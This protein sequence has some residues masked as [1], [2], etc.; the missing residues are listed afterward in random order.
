M[1]L[2]KFNK[3]KF[4]KLKHSKYG[5][6]AVWL[7]V[8]IPIVLSGVKLALDI[9]TKHSVD[10]N[11]STGKYYKRCATEAALAVAKNWNP[12]LTL[13]Q[14]KD[15]LLKIAD[16][17]YNAN[18]C[19]NDSAIGSAIPGLT[20]KKNYTVTKPKS[21]FA[22][23]I[24]LPGSVLSVN[25]TIPYSDAKKYTNRLFAYKRD[26]IGSTWNPYFV[27]WRMIDR[28]TS[29]A[30][31]V[32]AFDE[33]DEAEVANANFVLKHH[34]IYTTPCPYSTAHIC[35]VHTGSYPNV[36]Y[37]NNTYFA[38][39]CG[40]H[41]YFYFTAPSSTNSTTFSYS[42]NGLF[43]GPMGTSSSATSTYQKRETISNDPV[44]ISVVSDKIKVQTDTDTAY[45]VP[46]VC[47]VD[48]VLT[49]P[50]NAAASN[51]NNRDY[52]SDT[53][54][55]PS[56]FTNSSASLPT[57][58]TQ[59][60]VY[61]I[62]QALKN[63]VKENFYHTRGVNVGLIPYSA[64]VSLSPDKAGY[65][66]VVPQFDN[67]NFR[68]TPLSYEIMRGCFLYGTLG[69]NDAPL[70]NSYKWNTE[71]TGCPIMCRKGT[72]T[73]QST[74]AGNYLWQGDV[75]SNVNP[76]TNSNTLFLKMN[77]NP[78]YMG[79][80][81]LLSL[82]CEKT[83]PTYLP[84]P[85]Y[86]IEPTAD[87]VKIYE[88]CNAL[89]P[90][91]DLN[92]ISNFIF[93]PVT[94]ANNMFQAW[95]NNPSATASSDQLSRPSKLASGRKKVVI[96]VVNKPD[97]F[98]P[99]ELTYL[100][101]DN[102]YADM[103]MQESDKIDFA[104]NY[105][106]STKKFLDGSAFNTT[107]TSGELSGIDNRGVIA[108]PKKILKFSL[109][110]GSAPVRRNG[111]YEVDEG[112][113]RLTFPEK[114]L[115]K[116]VA[117]PASNASAS[118]KGYVTFYSDNIGSTY[119]VRRDS[120]TGTAISLGTAQTVY[121]TQKFVFSGAAVLAAFADNGNAVM[122]NR[123]S[124][125][126][127]N[128]GANLSVYKV[129][130][131][132]T[133]AAIV[134][135][136]LK[137]Q[138]IRYY[139]GMYTKN[140]S[141]SGKKHPLILND[142]VKE[143]RTD[144]YNRYRGSTVTDPY[145]EYKDTC[146]KFITAEFYPNCPV[147]TNYTALIYGARKVSKYMNI[148]CN[149]TRS[150]YKTNNGEILLGQVSGYECP[151]FDLS[152]YTSPYQNDLNPRVEF[153]T[154]YRHG[155]FTILVQNY[156]DQT[157]IADISD[158][159]LENN[160]GVGLKYLSSPINTIVAGNWI[161]FQ[162]DGELEVTVTGGCGLQFTNVTGETNW[163]KIDKTQTFFIDPA[164]ISD[165]KDA[166]G[167]YYVEFKA[168][169]LKLVSAELT[170]RNYEAITPT[171]YIQGTTN[172]LK[173]TGTAYIVTNVKERMT[174]KAKTSPNG[175]VTFYN[176]NG[177]T[178][179]VGT[180]TLTS[181][182]NFTFSGGSVSSS[183][184]YSIGS[185]FGSNYSINKVNYSLS[186]ARITSATL[187]NQIIRYSSAG[188]DP[189]FAFYRGTTVLSGY[190]SSYYSQWSIISM[191]IHSGYAYYSVNENHCSITTPRYY[192]VDLKTNSR[193]PGS[194]NY[195][196]TF[197][198]TSYSA[199]PQ[200]CH[201]FSG[202]PGSTGSGG[203]YL[204][205]ILINTHSSCNGIRI[206]YFH[207]RNS[208][209]VPWSSSASEANVT[210]NLYVRANG[211]YIQFNGDGQ[212]SV[213]VEPT[214]GSGTISYYTPSNSRGT[215][216]ITSTSYTSYTIDPTVHRFE[217]NADGSFYMVKLDLNNIQLDTSYGNNG[218][219]FV[220][221]PAKVY[222]FKNL[223][224]TRSNT[225]I[226]AYDQPT[227]SYPSSYLTANKFA[228]FYNSV[229][230]RHSISYSNSGKY[231]FSKIQPLL[232]HGDITN[233]T[234]DYGSAPAYTYFV[235]GKGA[236]YYYTPGCT[237][238]F[239][240]IFRTNVNKHISCGEYSSTSGSAAGGALQLL[241]TEITYPLNN[242]LVNGGFQSSS[243]MGSNLGVADVTIKA[244]EKLKA[245]FGSN[246]RVYVI[247]YRKQ[248]NSKDVLGATIKHNYT[249]IDACATNDS[250]VYDLQTADQLKDTL[251]T[252]AEDIKTF[253]NY[254]NA[255]NVD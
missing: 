160:R 6:I 125:H 163:S 201:T 73:Y 153:R 108:G 187:S 190:N 79:Y 194:T 155:T 4:A 20:L 44:S 3:Q 149:G 97:W 212:L 236:Q 25:K 141:S 56:Q 85:Y 151:V 229:L 105:T 177:V 118:A 234:E 171:C 136:V 203:S 124:S 247:K 26:S 99:G 206:N 5:Y 35:K 32:S 16:A 95:T 178:Q 2:K 213:T 109:A 219:A 182:R 164:K 71:L 233:I 251:T 139:G 41:S 1:M 14:Q 13:S 138:V 17:V 8:F 10:L 103:P 244:C 140:Y 47:N 106:D 120:L 222:K 205:F 255:Q 116:L 227:I 215:K 74:Y 81:N 144:E 33:V 224:T 220:S 185:N 186:N 82:R 48:I 113:C 31:R 250:Y 254:E 93:I 176:A 11:K 242:V 115:I 30:N 131:S 152:S 197:P 92:N 51:I 34:D 183:S 130:Y 199:V 54:E 52:A 63:F 223:S 69:E 121:G 196:V 22:P 27:M 246:L 228:T 218:V 156:Y 169:A 129:R 53:S 127:K 40:N 180:Y 166:N 39:N 211:S 28:G 86:M 202:S 59:T 84:N 43:S 70:T 98:E 91:Y 23:L 104:I 172:A 175:S 55:N 150:Y 9:S 217:S 96:L 147:I 87:L 142:G 83:C 235:F 61:Q 58:V 89:Y 88:F 253:A 221:T 18:P 170:N 24:A 193:T 128:F 37:P 232:L 60:P 12:G 181:S 117:A 188:M 241:T 110:D 216:T 90:I 207:V 162:G 238:V 161:C 15:A 7:C 65:T 119:D 62:G 200:Y 154:T 49:A 126:G 167:N 148:C 46:A 240:P 208:N 245:D 67:R 174:I 29:P 50:V 68:Q 21:I 204:G 75:L 111:Y 159:D 42:L 230:K 112:T 173:T 168:G 78:C 191:G 100:G 77:L 184:G 195:G 145:P 122:Y 72:S 57:Y 36:Y 231:Y 64:K 214:A 179:N 192:H 45:A 133:N 226:V 165:T 252:I 135:C 137:K 225:R 239:A 189:A 66:T 123:C 243:T 107:Y 19:Y 158:D 38:P 101:F 209:T 134:N 143:T 198:Y 102:D 248:E 114:G 237:R 80:A 146:L 94:W 76:S 157:F 210:D 132:L 249:Y